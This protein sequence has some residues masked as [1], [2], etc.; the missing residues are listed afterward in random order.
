[1]MAAPA[2]AAFDK[3]A[4]EYD[5]LWSF[6]AIGREQRAAVWRQIDP[7]FHA[8]DRVLDI[9]CG[10]GVDASHLLERGSKVYAIDASRE[11][12]RMARSRGVDAHHLPAEALEFLEGEFDGAISN[13][14]ALNCVHDLSPVARAL[15]R[16]VR[17][18]RHVAICLAG[19]CCGWEMAHFIARGQLAKAFRRW[20][21]SG[22]DTALGVHVDYPSVSRL[23][24]AFQPDFRLRGWSGIGLSVP[25]S[26][27]GGI[28]E[29]N[30][31][32]LAAVDRRLAHLPIFRGF[33][34]H[35]LLVFQRV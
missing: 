16:L 9:G 23:A 6:S 3:L 14:G 21:R 33:A 17:V 20:N 5:T 10:T 13:F 24:R 12:V 26:Y 25:P 15:G 32:R 27:V 8:G 31:T 1:M 28:S 7:L 22:C 18:G 34:D 2:A 11:M 19:P 29:R 35:R 30:I 4:K